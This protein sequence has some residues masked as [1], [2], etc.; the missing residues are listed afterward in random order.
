[1]QE[2][3]IRSQPAARPL[4]LS[5]R[6]QGTLLGLIGTL[7]DVETP[8]HFRHWTSSPLQDLLPHSMMICGL[9]EIRPK[10]IN[11]R[12]FIVQDWSL[13]Y[14]DAN[15]Q[16]DGSFYSPVMAAWNR[17]HAPQ[18]YEPD[19]DDITTDQ[20][21]LWREV[22]QDYGLRNIAAHGVHDVAGSVTSYFNFSGLPGRL[23]GRVSGLLE[24]L[25]PHMH[26]ALTRALS[27]EPAIGIPAAKEPVSLTAR[28]HDVLHWMLEGK[29]NWEIGQISGRSQHTIK[30]QVERILVKLESTNR[31]QA[32]ARAIIGLGL[33]R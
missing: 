2:R 32:V 24:L 22:F 12:K 5:K 21:C 33:I 18:L 28:E 27:H 31:A 26:L 3:A 1:M 23:D 8:E 13:A 30:H 16:R 6:E 17:R 7:L 25:T 19:R 4:D 29:T 9:A 14:L 20:H 15:R 11:I 10:Q